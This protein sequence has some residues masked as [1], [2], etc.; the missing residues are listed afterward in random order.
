[1]G[2]LLTPKPETPKTAED[3]FWRVLWT[4]RQVLFDDQVPSFQA[5]LRAALE[6]ERRRLT[7]V[8]KA[9][10]HERCISL[11]CLRCK[12]EKLSRGED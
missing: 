2:E 6:V 11:R 12:L 1:M 5:A 3:A 8:V 10:P 9:V 7:A 4:E